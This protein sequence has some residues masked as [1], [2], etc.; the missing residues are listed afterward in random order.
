[1][2]K[3]ILLIIVLIAVAVVLIAATKPDEFKTVRSITI[4]APANAVFPYLN[5]LKEGQKWSPWVAME[6][7]AH[8]TFEGPAEGVGA[9]T[10]W[11]GKKLGAGRMT[12]T[13]SKPNE[14]VR[15]RLEFLKPF[16]ATNTAD[17]A[18]L[19]QG[20]STVVT[21]SMY[22]KSNFMSKIMGV[23]MNCEKMVGKQFDQGL[24]N[25]KTLVEKK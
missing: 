10:S 19:A 25:L 12:I 15:S 7:D 6:P 1:M 11:I 8:Y 21:W 18:L 3:I 9:S 23:F 13:E 20:N 22:G 16:K 14:L 2:L 4:N 24:N 17:Y 5:N